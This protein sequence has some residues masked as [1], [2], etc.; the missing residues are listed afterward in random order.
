MNEL[1]KA[2][3]GDEKTKTNPTQ[4]FKIF[5]ILHVREGNNS[6]DFDPTIKEF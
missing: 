4:V 3:I 5:V 6:L 2:I 1:L